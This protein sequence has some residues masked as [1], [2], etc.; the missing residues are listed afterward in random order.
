MLRVMEGGGSVIL[1]F[2]VSK[3]PEGNLSAA[4]KDAKKRRT[5]LD[6]SSASSSS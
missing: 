2:C 4:E 6:S 1:I 5:A 3:R